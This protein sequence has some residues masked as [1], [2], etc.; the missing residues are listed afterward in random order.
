MSTGLAYSAEFLKHRPSAAHPEKPERLQAIHTALDNEGLLDHMVNIDF[1]PTPVS[2]IQR[3]HTASYIDRVAASCEQGVPYIDSPDSQI[4]RESYT[5]ARL[6]VG[7]V[8]AAADAI[9]AKRLTNALCLVRPPG[10]HAEADRSMGFCL[11]NNVAIAAKYLLAKYNLQRILVL[12]WDVHHGNGTQHAFEADPSVFYASFHQSPAS[13]YPGTGWQTEKGTGAGRGT[14]L[15]M[16]FEPGATDDDYRTAWNQQLQPAVEVFRPD[17]II[18]S[19]GYDAHRDDPLAALN[20]STDG[21][22]FLMKQTC[23]LANRLA[24]SR[25]LVVLE[26][27]YNLAVLSEAVCTQTR[28]LIEAAER[29]T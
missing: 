12:D 29:A 6:A 22:S 8:L 23:Q 16:P 7:A 13:C 10:H 25:L 17:F 19:S 20:L 4:C 24:Q 11:F 9:M 18:V 3:V 1:G 5:V 2:E 15:N 27:G 14:I 28:I 26:G 21:F